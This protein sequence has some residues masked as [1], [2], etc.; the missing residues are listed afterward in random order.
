MLTRNIGPGARVL[1]DILGW[2]LLGKRPNRSRK[3]TKETKMK[4]LRIDYR[5][6]MIYLGID[7]H[8]RTYSVT[9]ICDELIVKRERSP[10]AQSGWS[11]I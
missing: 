8:K 6:K 1:K 3:A 7:V 5:G 9:V 4:T 10:R 2:R 11:R